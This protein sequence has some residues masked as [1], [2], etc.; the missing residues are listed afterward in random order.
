MKMDE[1]LNQIG[2]ISYRVFDPVTAH[3]STDVAAVP[4]LWVIPLAVYLLTFV[5]AFA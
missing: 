5:V 2:A 3:V 1:A 4:M